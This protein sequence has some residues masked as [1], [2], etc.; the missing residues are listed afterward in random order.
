MRCFLALPGNA[1]THRFCISIKLSFFLP[2]FRTYALVDGDEDMLIVMEDMKEKGF[3]M[4]DRHVGLDENHCRFV[5]KEVARLHAASL[6]LQRDNPELHDTLAEQLVDNLFAREELH[7][8]FKRAIDRFRG[9][10][11]ETGFPG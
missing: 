7:D 5:L 3:V 4:M 9:E 10:F 6:A 1:T 2:Y 8:H 11:I